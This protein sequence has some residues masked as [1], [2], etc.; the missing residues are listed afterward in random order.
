MSDIAK[1]NRRRA[2]DDPETEFDNPEGISGCAGLTRGEKLAALGR[3]QFIVQRR[4][5]SADEGM[6]EQAEGSITKDSELLRE[7]GEQID[8]LKV[9]ADANETEKIDEP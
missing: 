8:V 9:K 5:E 6:T 3:W 2:L 7:I 1:V 4:L